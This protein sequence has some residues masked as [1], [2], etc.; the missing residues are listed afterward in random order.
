MSLRLA[1]C[2]IVIAV[3]SACTPL[4]SKLP[5]PYRVNGSELSTQEMQA[6]ALESC[7]SMVES[8]DD[9][10]LPTHPFTTDGCSAWPESSIQSCCLR[11]DIDYWCGVGDR[12][13]IDDSFRRCV[14]KTK[15]RAY[16]NVAYFGVRLGGGR[17]MPFPWRFGYGHRWPFRKAPAPGVIYDVISQSEP[18]PQSPLTGR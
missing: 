11:H 18:S 2:A 7:K 6:F 13:K 1:L 10:E 15:G 14:W 16:A 5:P 3:F 4:R 12:Q 9:V 17:F 8:A